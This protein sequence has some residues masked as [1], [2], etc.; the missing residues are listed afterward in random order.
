VL[1]ARRMSLRDPAPGLTRRD[2]EVLRLIA[3][4]LNSRLI[5]TRLSLSEHT[6]HRHIAN[7]S[8]SSACRRARRRWRRRR[9]ATCWA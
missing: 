8:T 2:L 9:G 1:A 6:V 3:A 5:A 4:D 7:S